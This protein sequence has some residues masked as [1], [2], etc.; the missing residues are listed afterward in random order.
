MTAPTPPIQRGVDLNDQVYETLKERL[1]TRAF[2]PMEK[3]SLQVLADEF[4]LSRSP[5]HHALTRLM[6]EGLVEQNQR[7][8]YARPITAELML[9]AHDVRCALELFAADQTVGKL[10]QEQLAQLRALGQQTIDTVEREQFLDKRKYMLTN[11]AFHEYLVDLVGNEV[12]SATY[13]SLNVH[14]LMEQ[15]LASNIEAAGNSSEEHEMIVRAYERGDVQAARA[16]IMAN[17]ETGKRLAL[18]ALEDAG[19]V[20]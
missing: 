11:E 19:G 14:R 5:V 17:V 10:D 13:R 6:V 12:L 16:A 15:T 7:G 9:G 4:G 18:R 1:L 8:Y 2:A 20:L 3:L